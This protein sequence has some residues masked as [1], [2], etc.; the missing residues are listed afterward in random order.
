MKKLFTVLSVL[1]IVTL[2]SCNITAKKEK[3]VTPCDST[4][5]DTIITPADSTVVVK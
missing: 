2:S 5:I 3:C 1:M 4:Q